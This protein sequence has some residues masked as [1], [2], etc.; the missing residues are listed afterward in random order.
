MA[1]TVSQYVEALFLS[2]EEVGEKDHDQIIE[3]LVK[4]LKANEDLDK[5][6]K[7]IHELEQKMLQKN[8]TAEVTTTSKMKVDKEIIDNIN[9][10]AGN[11]ADITHEVDDTLI[12]G[13]IIK[14]DDTMLDTSIKTKLENLRTTLI[15]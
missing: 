2:L 9:Q 4:I 15:K 10:L 12:G 3:N 1:V 8:I 14:V 7:I 5:F 6:E 11:K 13:V